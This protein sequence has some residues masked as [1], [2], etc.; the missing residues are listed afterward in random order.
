MNSKIKTKWLKALRSGKY[1]QGAGF[2]LDGDN[3]Y[4]EDITQVKSVVCAGCKRVPTDC[5]C[6][7]MPFGP[8]QK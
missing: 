1:K 3:L 6:P 8:P 7:G 2:L 4:E 5:I